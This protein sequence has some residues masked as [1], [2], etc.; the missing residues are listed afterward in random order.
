MSDCPT[1]GAPVNLAPDGD[2]RYDP[3]PPARTPNVDAYLDS[4]PVMTAE[5]LRRRW[6][7]S[8]E[9]L[10]D[11][12]DATRQSAPEAGLRSSAG[13]LV[14]RWDGNRT[15]QPDAL[16]A[17]IAV[18]RD[19]LRNPQ[20]LSTLESSAAP[21]PDD[22]KTCPTGY[23]PEDHAVRLCKCAAP[24]PDVAAHDGSTCRCAWADIK[25]HRPYCIL[26]DR[27]QPA[28]LEAKP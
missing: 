28:A 27:G 18:L 24:A 13:W 7:A 22:W 20:A 26:P 12:A 14:E 21:A 17:D 10:L 19:A 23:V 2:P 15:V 16:R 4:I 25:E 11:G 9:R 1:C 5:E 3:P 6:P 8:V